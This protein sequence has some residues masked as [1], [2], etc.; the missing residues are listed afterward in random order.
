MGKM[1]VFLFLIINRK[2]FESILLLIEI[3]IQ[4]QRNSILRLQRTLKLGYNELGY[5]EL[6]YNELGC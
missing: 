3:F 4:T 1:N 2:S 6:G 5:N